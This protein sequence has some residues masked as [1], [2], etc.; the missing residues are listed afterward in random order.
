MQLYRQIGKIQKS[1]TDPIQILLNIYH[2]IYKLNVHVYLKY[3]SIYVTNKYICINIC[4][5]VFT[6]SLFVCPIITYEPHDRFAS[7]FDLGTTGI[8][9]ARLKSSNLEKVTYYRKT[10]FPGKDG[11]PSQ[12]VIFYYQSQVFFLHHGPMQ[13]QSG[14]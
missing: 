1:C 11:F 5:V 6:V 4:K 3:I 14:L 9:L 7:H 8:F 13:F 10:Q 12:F 2:F